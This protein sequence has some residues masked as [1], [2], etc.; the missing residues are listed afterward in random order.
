MS[1]EDNC[2]FLANGGNDLLKKNEQY[3]S[4]NCHLHAENSSIFVQILTTGFLFSS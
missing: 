3:L 4:T 1:R 2:F